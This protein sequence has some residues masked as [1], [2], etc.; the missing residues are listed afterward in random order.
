MNLSNPVNPLNFER[1]KVYEFY[2]EKHSDR[3][4]FLLVEQWKNAPCGTTS[5]ADVTKEKK[6]WIQVIGLLY[7]GQTEPGLYV[8]DSKSTTYRLSPTTELPG[9]DKFR[10]VN[11]VIIGEPLSAFLKN[12][13]KF[14]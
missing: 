14:Y 1:G 9:R 6:D 11:E 10:I 4:V 13:I 2:F 8:F 7:F 5:Y 3:M 12:N